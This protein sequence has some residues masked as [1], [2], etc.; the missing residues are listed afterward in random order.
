[1][2]TENCPVCGKPLRIKLESNEVVDWDKPFR[3]H[4]HI[5]FCD[6]CKRKIRYSIKRINENK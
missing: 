6:N 2:E 4:T 5:V 1:M 3:E